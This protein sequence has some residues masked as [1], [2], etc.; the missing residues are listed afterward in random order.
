M[1][2]AT[3]DSTRDATRDGATNPQRSAQ[4]E[5]REDTQWLCAH[6]PMPT[7]TITTFTFNFAFGSLIALLVLASIER[8][9]LGLGEFGFG[10][11]TG[12]SA[13]GGVIGS[14]ISVRVEGAIRMVWIMPIGLVVETLTY[15]VFALTTVA[16][17]AMAMFFVFGIHAA[18]W[19]QR[20]P[21]CAS[22]PFPKRCRAG[23]A[24]CSSLPCRAA[25]Q[26]GQHSAGSSPVSGAWRA[27]TGSPSR[28]A[29]YC[30]PRSRANSAT[31]QKLRP[32]DQLVSNSS[33]SSRY[34]VL[35]LLR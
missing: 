29:P 27:L 1:R 7:P 20:R 35:H 19:E 6:R 18:M 23:L 22:A 14:I 9:R 26:S 25:S 24:A 3:R 2:D 28:S 30:S 11:L 21:R 34:S 10:L 31:S 12:A 32:L 4:R 15:L 33:A 17:V 5:I 13:A 16:W 8:L